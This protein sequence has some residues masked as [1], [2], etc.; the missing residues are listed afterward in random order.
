MRD[1]NARVDIGGSR[2]SIP[3]IRDT[4]SVLAARRFHH[5]AWQALTDTLRPPN[6]IPFHLAKFNAG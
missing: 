2:W 3:G 1:I 4:I 6:T 5:P